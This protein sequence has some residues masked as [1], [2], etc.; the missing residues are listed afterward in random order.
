M[1][2][3]AMRCSV[4]WAILWTLGSQVMVHGAEVNV[5]MTRPAPPVADQQGQMLTVEYAPGESSTPHMHNAHVFVYVL[6]GSIVMQVSGGDEVTLQA[7]DTFYES[8]DDVH[9]VSRN[10]SATEP[11]KFLV[12]MLNQEGAPVSVPATTGQ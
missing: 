6:E 5:L 9:A 8:P 1:K 10:A 2:K 4:L 3:I 11:A 12:V 7:G